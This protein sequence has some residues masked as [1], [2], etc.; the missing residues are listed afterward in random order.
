MRGTL[1]AVD[2]DQLLGH[3]Q[4]SVVP[5]HRVAQVDALRVA[6]L[7]L[8]DDRQRRLQSGRPADVARQHVGVVDGGGAPRWSPLGGPIPARG[9]KTKQKA[10]Q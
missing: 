1:G 3:V 2:A 8:P 4:L 5:Q 7:Q 9:P 10:F 6:L